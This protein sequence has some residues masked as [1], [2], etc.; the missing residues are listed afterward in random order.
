MSLPVH[1]KLRTGG[2]GPRPGDA[3]PHRVGHQLALEG[4]EGLVDD[5]Q[6][7]GLAGGDPLLHQVE[8]R[9]E[10]RRSRALVEISP[11]SHFSRRSW[12]R[13]ANCS[14][15]VVFSSGKP[16]RRSFCRF[17][18]E[19]TGISSTTKRETRASFSSRV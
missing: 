9:Q 12:N 16:W 2:P 7:Q 11:L 15:Q 3:A 8:G 5:A 6:L 19:M 14:T 17:S 4:V 10:P 13:A 1:I 18:W